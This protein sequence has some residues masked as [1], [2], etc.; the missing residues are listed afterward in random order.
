MNFRR[1]NLCELH[2]AS[3]IQWCS[4]REAV[5]VC[6]FIS[7]EFFLIY[8]LSILRS[9]TIKLEVPGK[10]VR[11]PCLALIFFLSFFGEGVKILS[12][13]FGSQNDRGRERQGE[14]ASIS[15]FTPQ[16]PQQPRLV[17]AKAV[18]LELHLD[19]AH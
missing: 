13:L 5:C 14:R 1:H 9:Y 17:Q 12:Y 18:S 3:L 8:C 11:A 10:Q 4:H 16:I 15:W 7:E 6:V 2:E 19:L